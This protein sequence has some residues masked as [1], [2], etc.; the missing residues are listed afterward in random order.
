M[1]SHIASL[2]WNLDEVAERLDRYPSMSIDLSAR[3][4][5]VQRQSVADYEKVRDFFIRYQDRILY[6]IDI[7]ISEGGD[8]FDTVSSEMLRKWESDWAYLA[9]DSIQVIENISG[10]IRGLHLPKTVIDKVYYENVNRYFSAFE[11]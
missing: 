7:T 1:A 6:G 4:G 2:E 5:H 10:D 3:M 9:T 11:K 8:R